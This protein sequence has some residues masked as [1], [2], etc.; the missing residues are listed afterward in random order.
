MHCLTLKVRAVSTL[1][2]S[3]TMFIEW[4]GFPHIVFAQ[5]VQEAPTG[6]DDQ[7]NGLTT[8]EEFQND[9]TLFNEQEQIVDGLGPVYNAQSCGECHQNPTSGGATQISEL[10]AG[11]FNGSIFNEHPGGSLIHARAID[12][13]IQERLQRNTNVRTL[14][15]A[16]STLG[17]GFVE[18]VPNQTFTAIANSQPPAIRGQVIGVP[19]LEANGTLR[20]GR[21]GWKNQHASLLSFAAD[22]YLNEMGI[23][24]PLQPTENSSNGAS[25]A[26]SIACQTPKTMEKMC[27][28]LPGLCALRRRRR[29]MKHLL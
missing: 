24:S 17:D 18:C 2:L 25:V 7:S 23:T 8:P 5:N 9:R 1:L 21:F 26:R 27:K 19:L 10:R 20:V 13:S 29:A 12:A 16:L 6:F 3:A 22:A 4:S 11:F 15:M 14:R 28:L